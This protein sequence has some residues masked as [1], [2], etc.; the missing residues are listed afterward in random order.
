[1]MCISG[2]VRLLS[3]KISQ[4]GNERVDKREVLRYEHFLYLIQLST[5]V[6]VLDIATAT[7]TLA[8]GA[9]IATGLTE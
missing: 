1:M 6:N 8:L 4:N 3:N 7:A 2:I 5:E 9:R